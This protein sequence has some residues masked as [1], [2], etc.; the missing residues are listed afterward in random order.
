M[1]LNRR[2]ATPCKECRKQRR[3]CVWQ[4]NSK[5]C[6]RCYRLDRKCLSICDSVDTNSESSSSEQEEKP[7]PND[8]KLEEMYEQVIQLEKSIKDLELELNQKK[9]KEAYMSPVSLLSESDFED[10]TFSVQSNQLQLF[11][12]QI[13]SSNPSN[14]SSRLPQYEWTLGMVNGRLQLLSEIHDYDELLMYMS[15]SLRYLSPFGASFH[16]TSIL[17]Q[18]K[19]QN[20]FM[21]RML[22]LMS[23]ATPTKNRKPVVPIGL[24]P[25]PRTTIDILVNSFFHCINQYL[26]LIHEPSFREYYKKL[27]DPLS[28]PM[29]TAICASMCSSQCGHLNLPYKLKRDMSEYFYQISKDSLGDI[30]DDPNRRLETVVTTNLLAD[31]LLNMMRPREARN[32]LSISLLICQDLASYYNSP[33]RTLMETALY[34]RHYNASNILCRVVTYII[35]R[36]VNKKRFMPVPLYPLPGE[37][38]KT[39]AYLDVFNRILRWN[40]HPCVLHF[41]DQVRLVEMGH[42]GELNIEHILEFER[43]VSLWWKELP[44]ELKMCD[45]PFGHDV[46]KLVQENK[47]ELQIMLITF[48][49]IFLFEVYSCLVQPKFVSSNPTDDSNQNIKKLIQ[50]R[51]VSFLL[52]SANFLVEASKQ[53]RKQSFLCFFTSEFIFRIVDTLSML[54][55]ISKPSATLEAKRILRKSLKQLYDYTD[56]CHDIKEVPRKP[57][58]LLSDE[59]DEN[60]IQLYDSFSNPRLVLMYDL[61]TSITKESGLTRED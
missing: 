25:N 19:T 46:E 13:V 58:N 7:M 10:D 3:K 60:I 28:S 30:F 14:S 11:D 48:Y 6:D 41:L 44:E 43:I 22:K 32:L 40:N 21:P 8:K 33:E 37:S 26:P 56:I 42:V 38:L 31:F 24:A 50:E 59:S 1:E 35:E 55:E 29:T 36:R 57:F 54:T 53:I 27:V 16:T 45:D 9:S 47:V 4:T 2:R 20:S 5:I 34:N 18:T 51:A 49:H 52:K 61:I 17:F 12:K 39:V 15:A 23:S